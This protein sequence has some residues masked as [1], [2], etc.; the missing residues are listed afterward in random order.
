ME[1]PIILEII[2]WLI[3][4]YACALFISYVLI[5]LLSTSELKKY[6]IRNRYSDFL[7]ILS[8]QKLPSVSIIAPAYNEEKTIVDNINCLLSLKYKDFEIIIVNDGSK[9]QTLNKIIK[10]FRP[11]KKQTYFTNHR[12]RRKQLEEYTN[13]EITPTII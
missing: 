2:N 4:I 12:L 10:Y 6:H 8:F 9:D 11:D 7:K 1:F 3:F 5:A 13:R